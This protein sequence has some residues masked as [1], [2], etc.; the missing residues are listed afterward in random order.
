MVQR[1]VSKRFPKSEVALL[2]LNSTS[3]LLNREGWLNRNKPE[4]IIKLRAFPAIEH[5]VRLSM[6]T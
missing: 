4:A 6:L 3:D 2:P 5:F 1:K